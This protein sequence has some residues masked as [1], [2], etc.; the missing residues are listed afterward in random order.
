MTC[1]FSWLN[2]RSKQENINKRKQFCLPRQWYIGA[3]F[4]KKTNKHLKNVFVQVAFF[5]WLYLNTSK[6]TI[7]KQFCLPKQWYISALFNNKKNSKNCCLS[8]LESSLFLQCHLKIQQQ[9]TSTE[10]AI[11]GTDGWNIFGYRLWAILNR[12]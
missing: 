11:Y 8:C 9:G 10:V 2:L 12:N 1:F 4:K 6:Q 5:S 3:L 7:R